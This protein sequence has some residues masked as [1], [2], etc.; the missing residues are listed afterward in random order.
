MNEPF[1]SLQTISPAHHR[2]SKPQRN[3]DIIPFRYPLDFPN[4]TVTTF[5]EGRPDA[6]VDF[7]RSLSTS[8]VVV[9]TDGTVPSPLGAGGAG[10][11]VVC[12]RCSSSSSLSYSTGPAVSSSFSAES[13][14]LV[15]G[16]HS[17]NG[18]TPI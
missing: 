15:Y 1:A 9:W 7:L 18:I 10:V 11:Q 17:C 4:F 12:G 5:I 13:L 16:L 6:A 8:D 3:T 14:A 2:K